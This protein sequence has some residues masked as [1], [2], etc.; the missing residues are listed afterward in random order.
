MKEYHLFISHSWDYS[1]QYCGLLGL[2]NKDPT[3]HYRN[4]SVPKTDPIDAN[5]DDQLKSAIGKK[6]Q[7]SSCVLILA[8]VYASYKSWIN[9]E[10]KISQEKNKKIIAVE[11]WGSE[12]TSRPVKDAA[13]KIVKWNSKSI[14]NAIHE[15]CD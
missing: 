6:I 2:L 15:I 12:K 13:T 11:Y 14:I 9:T 7:D 1:S 4:Y 10:I 3:F 8:G 5:S